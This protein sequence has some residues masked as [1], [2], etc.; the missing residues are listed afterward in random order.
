MRVW[1]EGAGAWCVDKTRYKYIN[2][3]SAECFDIGAGP[4]WVK[5]RNGQSGV[6]V[7]LIIIVT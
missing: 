4:S 1:G 3:T 7:F 6:H 5:G 2:T